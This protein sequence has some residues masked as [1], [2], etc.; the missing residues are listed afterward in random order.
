[1][2]LLHFT[3]KMAGNHIIAVFLLALLV[4]SSAKRVSRL[5]RRLM[6]L[7]ERIHLDSMEFREEL[8][9]LNSIVNGTSTD[10]S[11]AMFS[12][13]EG[14]N[15]EPIESNQLDSHSNN[16]EKILRG[17]AQE[18]GKLRDYIKFLEFKVKEIETENDK[19]FQR[20][21]SVIATDVNEVN[22][23]CSAH[24][25]K[26]EEKFEK[27]SSK[28]TDEFEKINETAILQARELDP[29]SVRIGV[30]EV[31]IAELLDTVAKVE[32]KINTTTDQLSEETRQVHLNLLAR[33]TGQ[34]WSAFGN[35]FYSIGNKE[36]TWDQ[37]VEKCKLLGGYLAEPDTSVEMDFVESVFKSSSN[38]KNYR[39][40]W[41]GGSDINAEGQWAWRKDAR[42]ITYTTWRS[43]EPNGGRTENCLQAYRGDGTWNDLPCTRK[44][45]YICEYAG[46]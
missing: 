1:M 4:I 42:K 37:A 31:T 41:L 20:L 22:E 35:S 12:G 14:Q 27:L 9:R 8:K 25:L 15:L 39:H 44:I 34:T 33:V 16:I 5:E 18:K 26:F 46:V 28:V 38:I 40:F 7:E 32:K 43:G 3:V 36:L 11:V 29:L 6:L 10:A 13:E 45:A 17:F 21:K 24:V 19:N 2:I 30:L 23:S